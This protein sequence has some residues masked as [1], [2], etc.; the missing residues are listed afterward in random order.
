MSKCQRCQNK[1]AVSWYKTERVCKRCFR[2]RR[3][4]DRLKDIKPA[5][6]PKQ[7]WLDKLIQK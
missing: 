1:E 7:S 2:E 5:G 4:E 6:R 3:V